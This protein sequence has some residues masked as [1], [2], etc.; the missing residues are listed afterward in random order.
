MCLSQS[1]CVKMADVAEKSLDDFF[2]KRDKKKKKEK[3]KAKESSGPAVVAMKKKIKEK[4][5]P[6]GGKSE[7]PD[8]QVEKVT[9]L[10]VRLSY[11]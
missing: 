2:A 1:V 3:V 4:E 11:S 6:G 8:Q 5:K 10:A 7:S 9:L